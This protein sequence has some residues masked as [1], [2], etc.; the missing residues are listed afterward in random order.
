MYNDSEAQ[1]KV[2]TSCAEVVHAPETL[3]WDGKYFSWP[4]R[5]YTIPALPFPTLLCPTLPCRQDKREPKPLHQSA[6][7]SVRQAS[8][9]L[10][11]DE[12]GCVLLSLQAQLAVKP[13]KDPRIKPKCCKTRQMNRRTSPILTFL[14]TFGMCVFCSKVRYDHFLWQEHCSWYCVCSRLRWHFAHH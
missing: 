9:L 5:Y 7:V 2:G 12:L 13:L 11:G 14:P 10:A 4:D 3:R 6:L 1:S 8:L